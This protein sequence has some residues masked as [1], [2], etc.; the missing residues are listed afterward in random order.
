MST[1]RLVARLACCA[2]IAL[3]TATSMAACS[4]GEGEGRV[5]GS[6]NVPNCWTGDFELNPDFFAAVPYRRGLVL[7]IQNGSDFQNFSDGLTI[8]LYDIDQVRPGGA[9]ASGKYG[10][11]L[12][13]SLPPEVT[14][15]GTPVK[16]DPNPA[17]VSAALYLQKSCGTQTATL[18][19]V[20]EVTIAPTTCRVAPMMGADPNQGC[21]PQKQAPEDV[22][23]LGRSVI[24]FTSVANGK[25]DEETAAERRIAGCFDIYFADP[26][27]GAPGGLGPPPGCVGHVRGIF[28]FFF[29]RGRP[30]QPFP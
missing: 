16:P 5:T 3:A 21:D 8:L 10:E 26:R 4:Q 30:S 27:E 29:E 1:R 15:P 25:V 7:R 23:A 6:L 18:Q 12:R 9:T 2:F 19:A 13:V 14:P 24:A 22:G 28:S 11:A 20:D 17:L